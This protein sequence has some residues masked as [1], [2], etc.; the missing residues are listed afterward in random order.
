LIYPTNG[1]DYVTQQNPLNP[2]ESIELWMFFISGLTRKNLPEISQ[3]EFIF[4]DSAIEE[5]PCTSAYSIQSDK[6]TVVGILTGD[7][8]ALD[9]EPM[10]PNLREEPGH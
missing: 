6:G 8:K 10:P 4:D 3:F 9:S 7:L 2:D 1:F 5:F